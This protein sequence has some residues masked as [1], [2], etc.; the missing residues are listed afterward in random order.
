MSNSLQKEAPS[1]TESAEQDSGSL[2]APSK[3][4]DGLERSFEVGKLIQ[5]LKVPS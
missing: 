3:S 4:G 5:L 2:K 1:K